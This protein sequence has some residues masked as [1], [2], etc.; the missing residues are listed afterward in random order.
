MPVRTSFACAEALAASAATNR[1]DVSRMTVSPVPWMDG[2]IF[3]DASSAREPVDERA[4]HPVTRA[5][6]EVST[7]CEMT[8]S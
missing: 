1:T 3:G 6:V 4:V 5:A 8:R 7:A 2:V